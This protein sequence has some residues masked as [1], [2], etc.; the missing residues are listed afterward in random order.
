[1]R[2]TRESLIRI[3]KETAQE[4][5]FN[6]RGIIAAY[7]TGALVSDSDPLLGGT[8][9]I[10]NYVRWNSVSSIYICLPMRPDERVTRLDCISLARS[11]RISFT[12]WS[13]WM[14]RW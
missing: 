7:L 13:R 14:S 1:M 4:R 9:D 6:D 11:G 8:A 2:V 3:A 10:A 12:I 5:A